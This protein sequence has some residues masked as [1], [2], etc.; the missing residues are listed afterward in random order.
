MAYL[1]RLH[2]LK[3]GALLLLANAALI[4]YLWAGQPK[5]A[6]A[7]A[8][9]DVIGEGGTAVLALAWIFLVLKSRPAGRVTTLLVSGLGCLF[10]SWWVDTLDEFIALSD[11][12]N[13]DHW[14]ESMPLPVG[15][16]LLTL[17]IYHWHHEQLAISE[18]M[19]KREKLFREHRLFD[20]VT[21]LGGADYLRQQLLLALQLARKEQQP[22]SLVMLD[23]NHFARINDQYGF[24]EGDRVL[25]ALTQLLLLNLRRHDLLFRLAGDRFV[26][27][28]PNTGEAQARGLAQALAE[29]VNHFA[30][31]SQQHGE[32]I[33]LQ[34]VAAV[35]MATGDSPESLLQRL[36]LALAHAKQP[37]HVRYA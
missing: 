36:H 11:A 34:A 30:Y 31:H 23:L 20:K 1:M 4:L 21:P 8:W 32:R 3:I 19:A 25:Q 12:V 7:I 13:W 18:Q 29:A 2:R 17:G 37:P 16:L 5:P 22:L 10:F 33:P 6:A 35:V 28:L 14:L 27:L 24:A 9:T 26:A 15:M